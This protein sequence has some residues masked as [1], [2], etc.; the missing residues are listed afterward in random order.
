MA[1]APTNSALLTEVTSNFILNATDVCTNTTADLLV[2]DLADVVVYKCNA[3]ITCDNKA[4]VQTTAC[5]AAQVVKA[6]AAAFNSSTQVSPSQLADMT[7]ITQ[8]L[9]P[10]NNI[11]NFVANGTP[12]ANVAAA[13]ITNRCYVNSDVK[14]AITFPLVMLEDCGKAPA[15]VTGLNQLDASTRCA[16]GALSELIPPDPTLL[17]TN[18]VPPLPIWENPLNMT[19]LVCAA[20]VLLVVVAGAG[21]YLRATTYDPQS[22][23]RYHRE[24]K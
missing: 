24:L 3:Q 14:Q 9:Y 17:S 4:N 8:A 18:T 23:V 15:I 1:T 2:C 5:D 19:L 12:A 6:V 11:P 20:V 22:A 16:V 10:G 7:T 13:Y 21:I